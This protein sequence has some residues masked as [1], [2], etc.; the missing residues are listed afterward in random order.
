MQDFGYLIWGALRLAEYR[1]TLPSLE[2]CLP[3]RAQRYAAAIRR[4]KPRHTPKWINGRLR[5]RT[6]R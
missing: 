5:P 4:R 2:V 6:R 3:T 1:G